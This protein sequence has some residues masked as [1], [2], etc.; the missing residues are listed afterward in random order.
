MPPEQTAPSDR[1]Q[2]TGLG[3]LNTAAATLAVTFTC[4][5]HVNTA[6]IIGTHRQRNTLH[7]ILHRATKWCPPQHLHR[8]TRHKTQFHQASCDAETT[9][10][11]SHHDGL[12]RLYVRKS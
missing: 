8:S 9:A 4:T 12:A 5:A 1:Q 10:H 3:R 11:M 7:T 2:L 6:S